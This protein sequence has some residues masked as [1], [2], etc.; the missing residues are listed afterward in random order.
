[1]YIVS[2]R[3]DYILLQKNVAENLINDAMTMRVVVDDNEDDNLRPKVRREEK[4][5]RREPK[6]PC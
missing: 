2:A 4:T 1:M 3:R 5:R 6:L